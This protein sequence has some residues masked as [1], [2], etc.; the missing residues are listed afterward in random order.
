MSKQFTLRT[1][2][3]TT[4]G[5]AELAPRIVE[6]LR[7]DGE[8]TVLSRDIEAFARTVEDV[9]GVAIG[10]RLRKASKDG[11]DAY[12]IW[13]AVEVLPPDAVIAPSSDPLN[14]NPTC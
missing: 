9:T 11:M 14:L 2:P 4:G 1:R 3:T 7:T 13:I 10:Y 12:R 8:A 5:T 6:A